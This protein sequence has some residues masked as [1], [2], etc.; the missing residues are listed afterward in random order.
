MRAMELAV[1]LLLLIFCPVSFIAPRIPPFFSFF[2]CLSATDWLNCDLCG[3]EERE[4]YKISHFQSFI[5]YILRMMGF[6]I[7]LV[8]YASGFWSA[9]LVVLYEVFPSILFQKNCLR[10]FQ[11]EVSHCRFA[12]HSRIIHKYRQLQVLNIMFNNIYKQD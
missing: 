9:M 10:Q 12:N 11:V 7:T 8:S 4:F 5:L 3:I 2:F 1:V 6:L